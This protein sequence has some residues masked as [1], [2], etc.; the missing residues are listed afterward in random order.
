MTTDT[1]AYDASRPGHAS[2]ADYDAYVRAE[3]MLRCY[4]AAYVCQH[5]GLLFGRSPTAD[6][7][8]QVDLAHHH[9][10]HDPTSIRTRPSHRGAGD[11]DLLMRIIRAYQILDEIYAPYRAPTRTATKAGDRR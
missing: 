4:G 3:H 2:G 6:L 1:L 7:N 10:P 9:V 8:R 11:D 5:P